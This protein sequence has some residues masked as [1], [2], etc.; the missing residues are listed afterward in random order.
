VGP[1]VSEQTLLYTWPDGWSVVRVDPAREGVLLDS[2]SFFLHLLAEDQVVSASSLKIYQE[3]NKSPQ[4]WPR[5]HPIGHP[6]QSVGDPVEHLDRWLAFAIDMVLSA[7]YD[8]LDDPAG[9][10]EFAQIAAPLQWDFHGQKAI[11]KAVRAFTERVFEG[12]RIDDERE[13]W[14]PGIAL[15]KG[16]SRVMVP[17]YL[18]PHELWVLSNRFENQLGSGKT[19]KEAFTDHANFPNQGPF[20][21]ASGEQAW[22]DSLNWGTPAV[23]IDLEVYDLL[24]VPSPVIWPQ[25]SFLGW[26]AGS[27]NS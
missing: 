24:D 14:T 23:P 20:L 13:D 21:N 4:D 5:D 2:K 12:Y 3:G 18:L 10:A 19:L 25:K 6:F 9:E 27:K 11:R 16:N 17:Q 22:L 1:T 26:Y 15:G 8:R 7:V